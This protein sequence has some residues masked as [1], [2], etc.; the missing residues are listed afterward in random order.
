MPDFRLTK[1]AR[2]HVYDAIAEV[3]LNP[4]EFRW[5]DVSEKR[6][7]TVFNMSR[8]THVPTDYFFQFTASDYGNGTHL[9][10]QW[11]PPSSVGEYE[12][13]ADSLN[14]QLYTCLQWLTTVKKEHESVD[15]WA[16]LQNET[17]LIIGEVVEDGDDKFTPAE[18]EVLRLRLDEIKAYLV[19]HLP[20]PSPAQIGQITV[21]FNHVAETA[22]RLTKKEWKAFFIGSIVTQIVT[23]GLSKEAIH[24]LW[25]LAANY[26]LPLLGT[27]HLPPLP[28]GP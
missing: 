23:L 27:V 15:V 26:I 22:D 21:T 5:T 19:E 7:Y 13:V 14:E 17:K 18:R 9:G 25:T 16:A 11:T 2:T 1:T 8:I 3:G 12:V 4:Q 10:A 20:S 24:G 28:L 6:G